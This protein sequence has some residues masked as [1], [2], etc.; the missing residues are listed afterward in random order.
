MARKRPT[1]YDVD[2]PGAAAPGGGAGPAHEDAEG[3]ERPSRTAR[4]RASR[5]LQDVGEELLELP[6]AVLAAL[7]LP[8]TFREALLDAQRITSFGA[9]RRQLQFI[10]KLMRRLD[11]AALG[12]IHAALHS[13]R[14]ARGGAVYSG[15][16]ARR[17][18]RKSE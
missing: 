14:E 2:L 5:Q 17:G 13:R 6:A 15:E 8:D 11:D 7:P 10:G 16:T 1:G 18:A 12:A 9:K 3:T 4:K